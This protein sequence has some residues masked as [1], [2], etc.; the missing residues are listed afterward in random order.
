MFYKKS[1]SGF[2]IIELMVSISIVSVIMTVVLF[3]YSS[4]NDSLALSAAG[5]E[6]ASA[7]R[8][9]QTYGLSVKEF[10]VGSEQFTSG[11]GI[12]FDP[13]SDPTN[14]YIFVD[15]NGNKKYDSGGGCGVVGTE[16]VETGT[17]RNNVNV[18]SVCDASSCPPSGARSLHVTFLRPNPD[19]VINFVNDA[20]T[21]I[22]AL[23]GKITLKSAKGTELKVTVESTG[24]ISVQ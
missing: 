24:Q 1:L 3:T 22:G 9:A 23:T 18:S 14:Y 10:S 21:T 17:L 13:V 16:C 11:Y 8:Q 6:V 2:T 5:Q 12:Y 4:F 15:I 20:G 19:A 7:V